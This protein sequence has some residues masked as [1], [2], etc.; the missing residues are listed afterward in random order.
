MPKHMLRGAVTLVA[1][2]SWG[3]A[4]EV[5]WSPVGPSA[6]SSEIAASIGPSTGL[7]EGLWVG[8][9]N[10]RPPRDQ[11]RRHDTR[12][13]DLVITA[14]TPVQLHQVTIRMIDGTNLGGPMVT[15][16]HAQLVQ[17]FGTVVIGAGT[18]RTFTFLPDFV[19]TRPPHAIA[20]DI[21]F[22]DHLGAMRGVSVEGP[23]R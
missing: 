20:A 6:A 10:V 17:H 5:S 15:V 19:V 7:Q 3:C 4:S 18:K 22:V 14:G 21:S 9:A 1:L 16:P 23:W 2:A 11:G 13:F 8:Q 12:A